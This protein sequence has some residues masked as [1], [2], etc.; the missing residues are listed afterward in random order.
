MSLRDDMVDEIL[1]FERQESRLRLPLRV[2][3]GITDR[4]EWADRLIGALDRRFH[5]LNQESTST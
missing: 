1:D 4:R 5:I 2:N 3:D